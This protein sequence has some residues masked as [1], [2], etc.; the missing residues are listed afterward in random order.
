[1]IVI[2]KKKVEPDFKMNDQFVVENLQ[3]VFGVDALETS[4]PINIEV[5]TPAEIS[6]LFDAISYE[7][8][9]NKEKKMLISKKCVKLYT[10][11]LYIG[12]CVVRMCADM[13]GIETFKRG[14]TRYL[15]KK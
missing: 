13:L 15:S 7:K 12:S 1:M 3:Y 14:L 2:L 6:S 9:K 8:G 11:S 5:N 10:D 4:R